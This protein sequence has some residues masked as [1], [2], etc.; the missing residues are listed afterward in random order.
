MLSDDG[1]GVLFAGWFAGF[2]DERG[3]GKVAAVEESDIAVYIA[4]DAGH[5]QRAA[6]SRFGFA[7]EVACRS[8]IDG[9]ELE[10]QALGK[11]F[12][13]GTAGATY[14]I[15][16]YGELGF[17]DGLGVDVRFQGVEV[18][19]KKVSSGLYRSDIFP[20]TAFE[21]AGMKE[22]Q[23]VLPSDG[24]EKSTLAVDEGERIPPSVA[25]TS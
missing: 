13:K 11:G 4:Y 10:V 2:G 12:E 16:K 5:L 8:G 19:F 21:V 3:S 25:V 9:D 24:F 17:T 7:S 22:F 15:D 18:G 20:I 6:R 14:W 23:D 1:E